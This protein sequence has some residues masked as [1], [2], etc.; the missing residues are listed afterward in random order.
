MS[1]STTS[2]P[3]S[4]FDSV[5]APF[6][7]AEGLPFGDVLTADTIAQA[8]ADEQVSFG[9]KPH[10]FWT[11]P[12]VLWTFLSQ[13]VNDGS[14]SCRAAVARAVVAMALAQPPSDCDTGNY[15]RARAKLPT[16][17][18]CRLTLQVAV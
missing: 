7:Q 12:L 17:V 9:Q 16:C 18:L 10:S 11:P 3:T 5:L 14:K 6:C 8:F 2:N 15:C 4:Q 13:V 1:F